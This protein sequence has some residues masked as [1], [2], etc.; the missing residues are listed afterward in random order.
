MASLLTKNTL[1]SL[2]L[3]MML[4]P[5]QA[6]QSDNAGLK[7]GFYGAGV[8]TT[9]FSKTSWKPPPLERDLTWF[10]EAFQDLA[11]SKWDCIWLL[12]TPVSIWVSTLPTH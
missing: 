6:G 12:S 10:E 8:N 3:T 4:V 7:P 5:T 11:M 2:F 1:Q 9:G